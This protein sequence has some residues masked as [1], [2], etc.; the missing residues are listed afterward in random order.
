VHVTA[1]SGMMGPFLIAV[2][3]T[4]SY[5]VLFWA[6]YL[7]LE[8]FV[9]RYWPQ[10]LV[11]WTT[12]F[13]GRVRDP[14]VG[15]DVLIGAVIGVAVA[16]VIRGSEWQTGP[17]LI[18]NDVLLGARSTAG[19]VVA[20]V[21]YAMRSALLI[22]YLLFVLRVL[23]RNQWAAAAA[24]TATFAILNA[25]QADQRLIPGLVTVLYFGLLSWAVIRWGLTALFAALVVADMLLITPA[26]TDRSAWFLGATIVIAV[27]PIAIA[28]WAFFTST[29]GPRPK[30]AGMFDT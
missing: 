10:S 18:E 20:Q 28:T 17:T 5:G 24:L 15:R 12:L 14:I 1:S 21:I 16:L 8:P 26:T 9:R 13:S 23:L 22:F 6:I 2:C 29:S 27:L 4:V 30:R 19:A 25:L 11:S 3:T 7:A